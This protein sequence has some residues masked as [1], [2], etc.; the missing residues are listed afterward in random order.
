MPKSAKNK[1]KLIIL[2]S[3]DLVLYQTILKMYKVPLLT[4]GYKPAKFD[5][6]IG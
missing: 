3:C 1:L 6:N 4:S 2:S 5:K